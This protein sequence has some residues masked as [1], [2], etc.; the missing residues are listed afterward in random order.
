MPLF[1]IENLHVEPAV[2]AGEVHAI[3]PERFDGGG[4]LARAVLKAQVF[5]T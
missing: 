3:R 2:N 4:Y 1:E 5:F